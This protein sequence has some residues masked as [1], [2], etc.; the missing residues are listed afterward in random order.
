MMRV[1]GRGQSLHNKRRNPK[2]G[3]FRPYSSLLVM[4]SANNKTAVQVQLNLWIDENSC[5]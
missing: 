5:C 2:S 3:C 1:K 4:F